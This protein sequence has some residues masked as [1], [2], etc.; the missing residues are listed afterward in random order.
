[1]T[2]ILL[3]H[4]HHRHAVGTAF[5][6]QIEVDDFR[7]LLLQDRHKDFVQRHAQNGRLI[8]RTTGVGAVINRVFTM[9]DAFHGKHREVIHFVVITGVVAEWAFGGHFAGVNHPFQH[10]FSAGWHHQIVANA[11]HQLGFAVTQQAGKGV[12]AQRIRYRSYRTE[13]GG[14]IGTQRYGYRKWLARMR[15][16]PLAE[17]QRATAMAEPAHNQF[18]FADHL[19]AINAEVMPV[20]VRA[21]GNDQWPGNKGAGITGPAMLHRD[22]A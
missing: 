22:L 21:F 6:R 10:N 17:I 8:R 11:F 4:A 15:Q 5:R 18:V 19:L 2:R 14:R 13:D 20:F 12:F 16:L 9:G 7:K 1:M 3:L